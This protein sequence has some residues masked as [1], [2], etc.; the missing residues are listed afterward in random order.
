M[1]KQVLNSCDKEKIAEYEYWKK[2]IGGCGFAGAK[3]LINRLKKDEKG[4]KQ[5]S[6]LNTLCEFNIA[7]IL[8]DQGIKFEYEKKGDDFSFDDIVLSIKSIQE[9]KY[10]KL[11][12]EE[13]VKLQEGAKKLS[14]PLQS[15]ITH[16]NL[17]TVELEVSPDM[18]ERSEIGKRGGPFHSE[19]KQKGRILECLAEFECKNLKQKKIIFFFRQTIGAKKLWFNDVANWYFDKIRSFDLCRQYY[20]KMFKTRNNKIVIKQNSIKAIIYYERPNNVLV[21]PESALEQ[22]NF[23]NI[24]KDEKLNSRLEKIFIS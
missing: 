4:K 24:C 13:I 8:L 6:F 10:E 23:K 20:S 14:A 9:K 1:P 18:W 21:W 12:K 15:I 16:S 7:R 5:I 11:E 2:K 22:G 17:S 19:I 3:K